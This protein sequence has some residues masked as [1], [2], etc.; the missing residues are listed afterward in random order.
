LTTAKPPR[1]IERGNLFA[2]VPLTSL[3]RERVDV[4]VRRPDLRLERIVSTGHVTPPGEWYDQAD[5]EWVVV[6]SGA[7]RL[8]VEGAPEPIALEPGDYVLLPAHV[9]HRVEWTDPRVATVWLALHA[10]AR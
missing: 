9:R 2:D 10:T 1:A 7:A 3:A 4:L 6:L 5:D 8:R